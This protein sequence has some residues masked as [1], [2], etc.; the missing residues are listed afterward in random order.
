MISATNVSSDNGVG[1]VPLGFESGMA[2]ISSPTMNGFNLRFVSC[3]GGVKATQ[4]PTFGFESAT[5]VAYDS[6]SCF[7]SNP[8]QAVGNRRGSASSEEFYF[9]FLWYLVIRIISLF[10]SPNGSNILFSNG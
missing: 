7:S 4:S 9:A 1:K 6:V 10:G 2:G 8:K 3:V 5:C